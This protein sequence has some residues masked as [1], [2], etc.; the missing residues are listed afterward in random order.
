MHGTLNLDRP[1]PPA[2]KVRRFL[3]HVC[4]D[5]LPGCLIVHALL[6]VLGIA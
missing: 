4:V 1:A 5:C 3:R 2:V 6:H